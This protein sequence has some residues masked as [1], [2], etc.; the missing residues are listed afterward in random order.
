MGL[1]V[2]GWDENGNLSF[3][4]DWLVSRQ[5]GQFTIPQ[6]PQ[7]GSIVDAN[8]TLGT[9]WW[10]PLRGMI[11]PAFINITPRIRVSGTTLS[12][13]WQQP[14]SIWRFATDVIYGIYTE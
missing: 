10:Y 14:F 8:L 3:S 7:T 4:T 6:D 2:E 11:G 9:P 5:L 12:W 13:D 1:G